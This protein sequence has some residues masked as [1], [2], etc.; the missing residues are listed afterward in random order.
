MMTDADERVSALQAELR[1]IAR[2]LE[3][4]ERRWSMILDAIPVGIF[5]LDAAGTPHY[6]NSKSEELLGKKLIGTS[7]EQLAF[8][9]GAFVAGTEQPYPAERMPIVRALS[10]ER[11]RIDDME[12]RGPNASRIIE[13]QGTPG[14]DESGKVSYAIAAFSDITE[15]R[16]LERELTRESQHVKLLQAVA[17]ASNEASTIHDALRTAVDLVCELA[18]W[19]LGHCWLVSPDDRSTL[20][21]AGIWHNPSSDAFAQFI[22]LTERTQLPVGQGLAGRVAGKGEP[23]WILDTQHDPDFLRS[24]HVQAPGVH[25]AFA[26]PVMAGSEVFA[27][28]EFF[29]GDPRRPDGDFLEVMR[30]VGLQLGRVTQ[31]MRAEAALVESEQQYRDLVENSL[32]LICM[33]DLQGRLLMVNQAVVAN[34]GYESADELIGKALID[35][36]HPDARP[37]MENYLTRIISEGRAEGMMWIQRRNGEKRIWEYRNSLRSMPGSLTVRGI[38]RDVTDRVRAEHLRAESER[39]YRLLFERNLAAVCRTTLGG[40]MLDVNEAFVQIFGYDS[41]EEALAVNAADLYPSKTERAD[42]LERLRTSHSLVNVE[43]RMRRKDGSG[44]WALLSATLIP[45]RR[46]KEPQIE[47]TLLDITARKEAEDRTA[48]QATHDVLTGLPNRMLFDDRLQ[49]AMAAADRLGTRLAAVFIDLDRF[50]QVN[51][52]FGHAA[53]DLVLHEVAARIQ[54]AIRQSDTVARVGGDEFIALLTGLG[55][56]DD[57]PAA[58]TKIFEPFVM[59]IDGS[60][61]TIEVTA[62]FGVSIYPTDAADAETLIRLADQA[63]YRAKASRSR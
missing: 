44:F 7:P 20:V 28:L 40:A 45:D 27:V 42:L 54:A 56:D 29:A 2:R 50:K 14:F 30:H 58:C 36:V 33:H 41:R 9:Y 6:A 63:M 19:P 32:D 21:S 17:I 37:E 5:V 62:S 8:V 39:R 61:R 47:A 4:S 46:N 15:Q 52:E 59:P 23:L 55:P 57:A 43:T 26:F 1:A 18:G 51:D 38:A 16:R 10:G 49:Q 25:A 31:R 11:T 34:L 12:I 22:R 48:Y 60:G 3:E 13:V 35:M 24:H 53:G